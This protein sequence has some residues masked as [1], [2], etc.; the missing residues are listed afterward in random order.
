[1][2]MTN[3]T[4]RHLVDASASKVIEYFRALAAQSKMAPE[5]VAKMLAA[6]ETGARSEADKM[7]DEYARDGYLM[8]NSEQADHQRIMTAA[9]AA[10]CAA[11]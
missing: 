4:R 6:I 5:S 9:K 3:E 8:E 11:A 7:A 2:T 10:A 1:M